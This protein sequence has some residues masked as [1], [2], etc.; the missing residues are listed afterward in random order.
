MNIGARVEVRTGTDRSVT[1]QAGTVVAIR[2]TVDGTL[3]Y[4]VQCD[5]TG[6]VLHGC[7]VS[8]LRAIIFEVAHG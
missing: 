3:R 6:H 4:D 1:F 8:S 2:E 5:T 7:H